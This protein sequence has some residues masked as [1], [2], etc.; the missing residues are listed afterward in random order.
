MTFREVETLFHEAGHALQHVLS[1]VD[2]GFCAGIRNIA[3]DAVE[4]P[5]QFMENFVYVYVLV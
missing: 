3:W 5:S 1:T 2:E 4:V